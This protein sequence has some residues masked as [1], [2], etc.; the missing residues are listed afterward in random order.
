VA[1]IDVH[2]QGFWHEHIVAFVGVHAAF[3]EEL[4]AIEVFIVI[5]I[6]ESRGAAQDVDGVI[7]TPKQSIRSE[8]GDLLFGVT[9]DVIGEDHF[10]PTPS[11]SVDLDGIDFFG[12]ETRLRIQKGRIEIG[13][14]RLPL[15][16]RDVQG[17]PGRVSGLADKRGLWVI[18][19]LADASFRCL[20]R[21]PLRPVRQ[22]FVFFWKVRDDSL[23]LGID[24]HD[25]VIEI[26][27]LTLDSPDGACD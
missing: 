4:Q 13:P 6:I 1:D 24:S 15:K 8:T 3:G 23:P 21:H 7:V 18:P 12:D 17:V 10:E 11:L 5:G 14:Q 19:L 25:D 9:L 16:I 26:I 27:R 22:P 2:Q 20:E